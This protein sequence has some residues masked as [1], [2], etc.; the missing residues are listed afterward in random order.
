[1]DD[2][3]IEKEGI[4]FWDSSITVEEATGYIQDICGS[5]IGEDPY[6]PEKILGVLRFALE[7]VSSSGD[8]DKVMYHYGIYKHEH[9]LYKKKEGQVLD[10]IEIVE[11]IEDRVLS[12]VSIYR[13]P[14]TRAEFFLNIKNTDHEYVLARHAVV[15]VLM[16]IDVELKVKD[17]MSRYE[18]THCMKSYIE[19]RFTP[20]AMAINKS[21]SN[22]VNLVNKIPEEINAKIKESDIFG[23]N[24]KTK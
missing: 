9:D 5:I 15:K 22:F 21:E 23:A 16:D 20:E 8:Y 11:Y 24:L 19:K 13:E 18:M 2:K 10:I 17:M 7:E 12:L 4:E 1:M 14:I 3:K 6:P